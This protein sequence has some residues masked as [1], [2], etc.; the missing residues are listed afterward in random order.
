MTRIRL[1]LCSTALVAAL[2]AMLATGASAATFFV[3]ERG[4]SSNCSGKGSLACATI[5]EAITQAEKSP[6]PNTIEVEPEEG[7]GATYKE[8]IALVNPKA[9]GLTIEGSEPGVTVVSNLGPTVTA[10]MTGSVTLANFTLITR[11]PSILKSAIAARHLGL[12]LD[13]MKVLNEDSGGTDGI[14]ALEGASVTMNGGSIEMEGTEGFGGFAVESPLSLNGVT[15]LGGAAA[16][17]ESGGVFSEKSTLSMTNSTI[18][19]ASGTVG[20]FPGIHASKDAS[21]SLQN[22]TI[23]QGDSGTAAR[24]MLLEASP[25][26]VNGLNVEMGNATSEALAVGVEQLSTSSSFSHLQIGGSWRGSGMLAIGG[27][28]NTISDSRIVSHSAIGAPA[29][30]SGTA[31]EGPGLLLQ[32]SVVQA[33]DTAEASLFAEGGNLTLDSSEVLGGLDAVKFKEELPKTTA[34][35][36]VSASTLDANAPGTASD[37]PGVNGLFAQ[38]S[39]EPEAVVNVHIQ[40]SVVLEKQAAIEE[41]GDKANI[42]CSYSAVP[43]QAQAE[44]AGS[45]GIACT[46]GASGNAESNPISSL[47]AEPFTNYQLLAGS[48]AVD[49]VPAAAVGLPFGF[50]PSAADLAGNPRV[51]DGNGDCVAVQDEGALELQGHS[52]PCPAPTH[53]KTSSVPAKPA[54][55]ALS[56]SPLAFHAAPRGATLAKK[57]SFGAKLAWRDSEAATS[58]FTVFRL[59]SGRRQGGSCKRPSGKNRHGRRCTLKVRAGSF[60]H[61]D[62]AGTDGGHFSGRLKSR[63]LP[64]GSYR[65]VVVPRNANGTGAAVSSSFKVI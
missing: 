13:N 47:L 42:A 36:T 15:I 55:T 62:R 7:L 53:A 10:S 16:S 44:G 49:S 45:G 9:S 40:G 52:A 46:S 59:V 32:R 19:L 60:T 18:S 57:K 58:T 64:Q 50:A 11:T 17:D 54:I 38:A 33:S 1:T 31:V 56:I 37:A 65:L 24:G 5:K 39:T 12:T 25:A 63:R 27:T 43:N 21:V 3:N 29:L 35:V 8:T 20:K 28:S 48:S 51:V 30:L 4:A 6:P 2:S 23:K 61:A 22:D 41:A 34:T 26:T 14:E